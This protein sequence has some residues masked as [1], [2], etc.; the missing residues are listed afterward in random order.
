M[1]SKKKLAILSVSGLIAIGASVG[2]AT[3]AWFT[4]SATNANNTFTAGTINLSQTRDLGDTIPGPMFYTSTSDPTGTYPYDVAGVP[5][6]PP[7]SEGVGGLAPGDSMTR[8]MNLSNSGSLDAKVTKIWGS[9]NAAGLQ[10]G[11]LAFEEFAAKMN[12]KV[13]YPANNNQI[14]YDGPLNGL[15]NGQVTIPRP[16]IARAAPSGPLNI[17]FTATLDPSA[18]N[19]LQGKTFVFDFSFYAEQLRNNQ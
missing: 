13:L 14:M 11:D 15:L 6:A 9:V 8:A 10:P 3:Y 1:I 19:L 12:I 18:S 2:G 7:G 16:L 4:S 5:Y 17:T